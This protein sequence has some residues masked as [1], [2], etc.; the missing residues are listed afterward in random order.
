MKYAIIFAVAV[1]FAQYVVV[2]SFDFSAVA[3]SVE[4]RNA[5]IEAASK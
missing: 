1:A 2:P 4:A 5:Q 3:A